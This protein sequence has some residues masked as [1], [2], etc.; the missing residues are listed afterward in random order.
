MAPDRHQATVGD[1][2]VRRQV[3]SHENTATASQRSSLRRRCGTWN[4][5]SLVRE[6]KIENVA[7][8]ARRLK[9]DILGVADVGWSGVDQVKVGDYE[10]IYSANG[11]HTGVGILMTAEVAKC[12]MGY[13]AVSGRVIVAKLNANPFNI[14]IIQ[15]YA[16]TS[17]HSD[18]EIDEFYE[19]L[20]SAK[21]QAGSQDV[22]MVM[23]DLNAKVGS[24][25]S[26]YAVGPFGLGER[27]ERGDS[28]VEWC[29]ESGQVIC[30]TWFRHHPRHLWTWSSPGNRFRNQI[31]F[32]TINRRFRNSITQV[33]TYPGADCGSDHIPVVADVKLKLKKLKKK[34]VGPKPQLSKLKDDS[35]KNH[36]SVVVRNKYEGLEDEA[37]AEQQWN[38]LSEALVGAADEVVPKK[39]RTMRQEWMTEEILRKMDLRRKKKRNTSEYKRLDQEIRRECDQAKEI[40]LNERCDEIESLSHIN[41]NIMY[42]RIRQLTGGPR[43]RS[44][45]A[46]KKRDGEVAVGIDEVKQRWQEYTEELFDD[47]RLPFELDVTDGG[48]PIRKYEVEAAVKQMK[49]GKAIGEDGV[50]VEMVEALGDW[51]SDVVVQLANRI[52]DTGH[53]PTPMQLSTF[54]AIP[55]KPGTME[56]NKHRTISVMSQLGK[57]VL[58]IILNRIRNKIRPEISEEQYGF[59]KG[60]GTTNAIFI[61]RMLSE[62]AIEMQK[63][64][65]L[66]FIDYEKA[67]DTVRH[68]EML[69]MLARLG[70]DEKDLRVIK[71]LYYQQRAAVRVGDELTDMVEI[72]RGVRQGCVLSPDLFNLYGEVI[73]KEIDMMD[74]FSVGGRNLNNVRYA[75][76]TVIIA[77]SAEKLQELVNAVNEASEEKGLRIN[78]AKTE[79]MVVSKRNVPTECPIQIQQE[80]VKKVEEFQYLGSVLT[81]D[82][83][84][85]TEIKRR[86]GIGKT[87]FRK[88]KNVLTNSRIS[89]ETR[90]RAVKTYV[91]STLLYGCEAWTVNREMELRLEAMEMWC[92]R[93]MMRVS[94]TERRSNASILETIGG[95]RELLATVRQR[96][97]TFLGHVIR[98]DG[99]ENLTITGRIAGSRSRGRPRMK[100]VDRMKEYIGGVTTQQLLVMTRNREQWRSMSG[101]VFNGTPH[102]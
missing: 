12:L 93:R 58:R 17:D 16:P 66:C 6:G 75:D 14:T 11:I 94:W 26:G 70:V 30:N 9:L 85:T 91:W 74:G 42:S 28:W 83:R 77:D 79:C 46:I 76:D 41:R 99:L 33:K 72:K 1:D 5:R 25:S 80:P 52:Y 10:F 73:M 13:W 23:G 88:M 20:D 89:I 81:S 84:C 51:G 44:G 7:Q 32:F 3:I 56:C 15:V 65:Y 96:Q 50:A 82:A 95:R 21:R 59:V 98:A 31:D 61:L 37:T 4:V 29:E 67:F 100:Y 19:Q 69:G 60:K 39:E 64:V 35:I 22:I 101:N 40:W 36:Y 78:R 24:G 57:I 71:N 27:N 45:T 87:S 68:Q 90:K 62:R 53:I 43:N 47:N 86:I 97:M 63:D 8:E 34:K 102:R 2:Y 49:K 92:W 48:I 55:K 18:E 38:R 54:T